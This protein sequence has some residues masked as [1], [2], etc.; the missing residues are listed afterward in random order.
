MFS[1]KYFVVGQLVVCK[2]QGLLELKQVPNQPVQI[3][4]TMTKPPLPAY[5]YCAGYIGLEAN[6]YKHAFTRL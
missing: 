2:N 4:R 6:P 1:A 3:G 5:A